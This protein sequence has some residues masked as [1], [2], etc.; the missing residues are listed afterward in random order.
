MHRILLVE[1]NE[2]NRDLISRR[3]KR[4]GF[5]V[6][7]AVDGAEGVERATAEMPE[8]IVMDMGLPVL[9]G[10]EATRMLKDAEATRR[11]PIIGL[12]AHAMSGD[13]RRALDAG[14]D[15]YDTKPVDWKRLL[16]KIDVLLT[17]AQE[18]ARAE[19]SDT[20]AG[21]EDA[22]EGSAGHVLVVDDNALHREM[23]SGRLTALGYTFDLAAG[24][25]EALELLAQK[26]FDVVLL[27]VTLP[28]VDG[29]PLLEKIRADPRW[30]GLPVLLLTTIDAVS[31][32]VDS[33][34]KGAEDFVP[35]PFHKE[36]LAARL[37]S[38]LERGRL[39]RRAQDLEQRLAA[40]KE[41]TRH[42]LE[43][44]LPGDL[45][46]ELEETRKVLPR[47]CPAVAVL[48]GE[49]PGLAAA[50]A[51]L[52]PMDAGRRLQRL[53]LA[54]EEIF[55]R[56]QLEI[57]ASCGGAFTAA[58]GLF[59]AS[60][61]ASLEESARVAVRCA[62]ELRDAALSLEADWPPRVGIDVGPVI[63]GAVG[64]RKT[65]FDLWGVPV[66]TAA[67]VRRSG[68]SGAVYVSEA[69][70]RQVS[71]ACE[72][73]RLGEARLGHGGAVIVHRVDRLTNR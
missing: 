64:H 11:I 1:D 40:E 50:V 30:N 2:M 62:L 60:G 58:T 63:A 43:A 55:E 44:I 65:R 47:R 24:T 4:R 54:F 38:C 46:G 33:L 71:E 70:W 21:G 23:L 7:L 53:T 45:I 22:G 3:L 42:L 57:V 73:Q 68:P 69:V 17:R 29:Q 59:P 49:L 15:D 37:A 28:R 26:R 27:D 48:H 67:R 6:S 61:S 8:L 18:A 31:S 72:G 5:D 19:T 51:E 25:T 35:Q 9:D 12:S 41:R 36:V 32:A 10:Y 34:S 52:E 14:C 16:G 13:A 39:R 20:A 66:T 56:H